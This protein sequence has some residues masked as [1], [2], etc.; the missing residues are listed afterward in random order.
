MKK[1]VAEIFLCET[2][3]VDERLCVSST[4]FPVFLDLT[5]IVRLVSQVQEKRL[6]V[7][8]FI[9]YFIAAPW[10]DKGVWRR[11]VLMFVQYLRRARLEE[12]RRFEGAKKAASGVKR[13]VFC[14]E[15]RR[16]RRNGDKTL[17]VILFHCIFAAN[18]NLGVPTRALRTLCAVSYSVEA[19]S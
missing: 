5:P 9:F 11:L 13:Y 3:F 14:L 1:R 12:V 2:A 15:Q 19:V 18:N 7:S 8:I 10:F 16:Y 6:C 17:A 4:L